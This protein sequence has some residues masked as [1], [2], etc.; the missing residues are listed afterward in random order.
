MPI[1]QVSNKVLFHELPR[2]IG[3]TASFTLCGMIFIAASFYIYFHSPEQPI[4]ISVG[5]G[6]LGIF[7]MLNAIF[8]FF[9]EVSNS[10]LDFALRKLIIEKKS[11]FKNAVEE[12]EFEEIRQFIVEKDENIDIHWDRWEVKVE[13][14]TGNH[15]LIPNSWTRDLSECEEV[16]RSANK[17]LQ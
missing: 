3:F 2:S 16:V 17:F 4:W 13:L 11:L 6:L 15:F 5:V 1:Q 12:Y 14:K 10:T 8:D 9:G 7:T